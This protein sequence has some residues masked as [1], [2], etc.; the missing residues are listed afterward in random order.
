[1]THRYRLLVILLGALIAPATLAAGLQ[2]TTDWHEEPV[3]DPDGQL[4]SGPIAA[5]VRT[6]DHIYELHLI[7]GQDQYNGPDPSVRQSGNVLE[8]AVSAFDSDEQPT[9]IKTHPATADIKL[10]IGHG[11]SVIQA[12]RAEK[13]P[14]VISRAWNAQARWQD[15]NTT[16]DD[17]RPTVGHQ[18]AQTAAD[19]GRITVSRVLGHETASLP[20]SNDNPALKHFIAA[21]P[22]TS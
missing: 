11:H 7:C 12:F 2:I 13:H 5:A 3:H 1:M 22:V 4:I 9:A 16:P 18:L 21:C 10:T 14:N 19:G 15:D 8:L 20:L 17:S 6:Q